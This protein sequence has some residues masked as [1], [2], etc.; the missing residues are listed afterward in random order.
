MF[1]ETIIYVC[2]WVFSLADEWYSYA[3]ILDMLNLF[4]CMLKLRKFIVFH[5]T[6][7]NTDIAQQHPIN[8]LN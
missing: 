6:F 2:W 8:V 1:W 4:S 3:F 7:L 5:S